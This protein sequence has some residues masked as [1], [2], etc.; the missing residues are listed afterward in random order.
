MDIS[1]QFVIHCFV[2]AFYEVHEDTYESDKHSYDK[3]MTAITSLEVLLHLEVHVVQFKS[4]EA[5]FVVLSGSVVML[6][7]NFSLLSPE[8]GHFFVEGHVHCCI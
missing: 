4:M 5:D 1:F 8:T 2:V 7:Y 6:I 3:D